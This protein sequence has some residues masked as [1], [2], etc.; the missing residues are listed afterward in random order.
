MIEAE[1]ML[2]IEASKEAILAIL[3][4]C[5]KHIDVQYYFMRE[6]IDG[7]ISLQYYRE[8]YRRSHYVPL[9]GTK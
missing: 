2:V 3:L 7:R 6:V 8:S 1:Y 5:I 9:K 4:V